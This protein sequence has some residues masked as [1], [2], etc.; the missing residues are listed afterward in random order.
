[1]SAPL[2]EL[3]GLGCRFGG[4][5]ALQSLDLVVPEGSITGVIGPNGAG[6]TTLFNLITGAYAATAGE[7][8]LRGESLL[9]LPPHRIARRGL[10]RTFQNIRLFPSMTVW[11]HL[12]VAQRGGG[13]RGAAL[14]LAWSG[15]APR[16]RAEAALAQFDLV[17][18]RDRLATTLP[19]GVMRRVELARAITTAPHLLLLDEPV[20]GMNHAEAAALAAL[21]H[22]LRREGLTILLIEHDM[23]FVER[24]C[25]RVHVLDAGRLIASGTPAELRRTPAVI[26]AYLG[27]PA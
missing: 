16:T 12:L 20:A 22:R 2:L 1:M 18:C 13:W 21:L 8:L 27:Q 10:A 19:Y 5:L 7:V 15:P 23:G 14:P 24:L 17:E 25:D 3:R 26:D 11:E 6:K 9:G 4:I